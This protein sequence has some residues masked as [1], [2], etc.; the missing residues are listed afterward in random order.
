MLTGSGPPII[1]AMDGCPAWVASRWWITQTMRAMRTASPA[2]QRIRRRRTRSGDSWAGTVGLDSRSRVCSRASE[3]MGV[4][5]LTAA[6][7]LCSGAQGSIYRPAGGLAGQGKLSRSV[8]ELQRLLRLRPRFRLECCR[9]FLRLGTARAAPERGDIDAVALD[10]IVECRPGDA[11]QLRGTREVATGDGQ[12]LPRRLH[13][14]P[15]ARDPQIQILRI[16]AGILQAE[17]VRGHDHPLGH[18]DR[19]LEAVLQLAHVAWP[20]VR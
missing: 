8:S 19:A 11:E 1:A 16:L 5:P 4:G 17:V 2:S 3:V 18:D 7:T 15:L 6:G 14:R 9:R 12:R 20:G 13:F 10:E